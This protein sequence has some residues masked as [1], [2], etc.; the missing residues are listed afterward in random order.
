MTSLPLPDSYGKGESGSLRRLADR[1]VLGALLLVLVASALL[2]PRLGAAGLWDPHEVRLLETA[3]QPLE[4]AA[5]WQSKSLR[6]QLPLL[7]ITLGVRLFGVNE[8]GGRA[9]MFLLGLCVLLALYALGRFF[10]ASPAGNGRG[11]LLAGLVLISSPLFFLSARHASVTLVPML[12]HTLAVLGLSLL[13]LPRPERRALDLGLG[14]LFA[15]LGLGGGLLSIGVLVGVAAPLVTVTVVLALSGAAWLP[16]LVYGGLCGA[17]LVPALRLLLQSAALPPAWRLGIAGTCLLAAALGML[18]LRERRGPELLGLSAAAATVAVGLLPSLSAAHPSG[19]S[20]F[21]AGLLHWPTSREPQ[22]DTLI[23][24]LGFYLFPWIGLSPLAIAGVFTS[25]PPPDAPPPAETARARFSE[26]LPLAWFSVTYLLTTLHCALVGDIS[27]PAVPALALLIGTYLARLLDQPAAGG[28]AAGLCGALGMAMIGHD[29]FFAP[30]QYLSGHLSEPLRWPGPLASVGEVLTACG[31]VLGAVFGAGLVARH[32]YRRLLLELGIGLSL[33]AAAVAVHGL[34]P[35]LSSHVSYRGLYTRYQKLGGGAL[36]LFG[37]QQ[38]SGRIYGQNSVQLYSVPEVMQFLADKP[39]E[40]AFV[41][42]GSQ[43][44]G[45]VD[46]E[47]RLR[48]QRYFVVDDSN[49]QFIL[50]T[51]R[52]LAGEEDLNPLRRFVSD[53]EPHPQVPLR[54]TFDGKIELLGYDAP[55]EVS[56]GSELT[57]RLYYRALAPVPGNYRVFLHFDGMGTRW[58]GDHVPVGSKFPT[59]FWSPGTYITDEHRVSVSRLNQ[60]AGYYQIFTGFWPGGDGARLKVTAGNH[61][62]DHRVRI[63]VIRV[64]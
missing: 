38:S 37:V 32:F 20:P 1:P 11:A 7:P 55:A 21:Y 54:A 3:S 33:L 64:K 19:Y 59:N 56:R 26:L 18:G 16:Q 41:I 36:A 62:T 13:A 12:A 46:R 49:A 5:L 29:Y 10:C 40:R 50:I 60:P 53:S 2:A 44:L 58:N 6:P 63:G 17:A 51:N 24:G 15:V 45:A 35:A 47:A 48:G 61:E 9:P 28:V 8:L 27:F 25:A 43:E 31:V 39:S 42:V 57:I 30:E 22:I 52:L 14:L 4:T 23:R 34:A